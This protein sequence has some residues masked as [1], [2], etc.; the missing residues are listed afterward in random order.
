MKEDS[1]D[2]KY[3]ESPKKEAQLDSPFN[4]NQE[5]LSTQHH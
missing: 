4:I 1:P 5:E 3:L 2:I